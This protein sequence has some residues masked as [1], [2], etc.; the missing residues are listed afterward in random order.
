MKYLGIDFGSKK[1]GL[2]TSD[3]EG[4]MAFP[5][6]VIL[7]SNSLL[8]EIKEVIKKEKISKIVIGESKNFKGEPNEIMDKIENFKKNLYLECGLEIFMEPEFLT[9]VQARRLQGK[10]VLEDASA[11]SIILQ[12]FLDRR[13]NK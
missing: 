3:E 2:S 11:A 1:I 13:N 9:S 10:S 5:Y 4:R 8:Q 12:S 7:N 6:S